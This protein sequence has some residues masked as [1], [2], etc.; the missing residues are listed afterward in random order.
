V[1]ASEAGREFLLKLENMQPIGAF[2]PRGA[3][4]AVANLA[5]GVADVTCCPTSKH[6]R[7]VA[8]AARERGMRAVI[9]MF[10]LVAADAHIR[11]RVSQ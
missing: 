1:R 10:S 4:N 8:R 9:R 3:L 5:N 11:D 7:G 6:G 2:K